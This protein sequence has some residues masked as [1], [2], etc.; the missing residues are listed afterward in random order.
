MT[1]TRQHNT[2]KTYFPSSFNVHDGVT[3][4]KKSTPLSDPSVCMKVYSFSM[5]MKVPGFKEPKMFTKPTN[6]HHHKPV[7]YS[8]FNSVISNILV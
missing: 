8:F 4:P 2:Y 6:G 3:R 5:I 1:Q 7:Q